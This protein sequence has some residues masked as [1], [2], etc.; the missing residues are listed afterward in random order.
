MPSSRWVLLA[1]LAAVPAGWAQTVVTPPN[2]IQPQD[3]EKP[4]IQQ[5]F[6]RGQDGRPLQVDAAH[7]AICTVC[8]Q[9]LYKHT[10]PNFECVPVDKNVQSIEWV[11]VA[12]PFVGRSF[13]TAKPGNVNFKDGFD[14]DFCRH[15]V[16]RA[17]VHASVWM[18][19][20]SGYAA[21]MQWFG[22]EPDGSP[23]G[24][25]TLAFVQQNLMGSTRNQLMQILGLSGK[26]GGELSERMK[27]FNDYVKSTEIPDWIKYE[28]AL[29]IMEQ[30]AIK[31]PHYL[32]GR[33]E[34]EAAHANRRHLYSEIGVPGLDPQSLI[35]LS[36]SIRRMATYILAESL[37]I[38][39]EL[40]REK[41]LDPFDP[42]TDP[43]I[44]APAA[45]R[46]LDRG[47]RVVHEV[48][49]KDPERAGDVARFNVAD[50]F[51]LNLR[52]AGYLD[53]LGDL[54]GAQK[55]LDEAKKVIPQSL[56]GGGEVPD[57]VKQRKLQELQMLRDIADDRR[58]ALVRERD[59]LYKAADH[60]MQSLFFGK[61]P[62]SLNDAGRTAYLIGESLRRDGREPEHAALWLKAARALLASDA[63]SGKIKAAN[64]EGLLTWIENSLKTLEPAAKDK[65]LE[66]NVERAVK[67]VL[68]RVGL[69]M[70]QLAS[71]APPRA[72]P[73]QPA[74]VAPPVPEVTDTPEPQPVVPPKAG[75]T[76]KALFEAYYPAFKAYIEKHKEN[77]KTLG[78]LV[79]E[80][81]LKPE[82]ALLDAK[83]NLQCP[84][85]GAKL[86]YMRG[87]K[88]GEGKMPI[89]YPLNS[90]PDKTKLWADGRI[91]E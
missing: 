61:E 90:D 56:G 80:G 47:E 19:P 15:S 75:L 48:E 81:F 85:S 7:A 11:S 22:K 46:I 43:E 52:Y 16:G 14:Y 68:E 28:N 59:H 42:T 84:A 50:I 64:R 2:P 79:S 21:P 32:M 62:E 67:T 31:A 69:S 49:S 45:K 37:E 55:A 17:A 73:D 9:P 34:L 38:R 76:R 63:V 3:G 65:A 82:Q 71:G 27:Q 35:T 88:L 54:L 24:A 13:M 10:D 91:G 77:P 8:S 5:L 58:L 1:A 25:Q 53:R 78:E 23:L 66:P 12:S 20:E 4:P 33:L 18:D 41:F 36:K 57:E 60:L 86:L 39:R 51:V 83:G 26:D 89:L 72:N 40:R 30:S 87:A 70:E 44:L 74:G 29:K 6:E